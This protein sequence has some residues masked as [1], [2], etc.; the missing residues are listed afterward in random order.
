[1]CLSHFTD[2]EDP[3]P[4]TTSSLLLPLSSAHLPCAQIGKINGGQSH[5][6]SQFSWL[7][8]QLKSWG[9]SVLET[10][11]PQVP[12]RQG[13]EPPGQHH[14]TAPHSIFSF[15]EVW[16][17]RPRWLTILPCEVIPCEISGI[18]RVRV[19]IGKRGKL[20]GYWKTGGKRRVRGQRNKWAHQ[21][22]ARPWER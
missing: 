3:C 9:N 18:F 8:G 17:R 22:E 4:L 15:T 1:M 6:S 7:V 5:L 10:E 13:Q 19:Y 14:S 20:G 11:G 21:R 2:Q 12:E 16:S